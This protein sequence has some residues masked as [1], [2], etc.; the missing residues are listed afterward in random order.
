MKQILVGIQDLL[1]QPNAADPAQTEGYHLFIQVR[2][3]PLLCDLVLDFMNFTLLAWIISF[4][5]VARIYQ[6]YDFVVYVVVSICNIIHLFTGPKQH[7]IGLAR[8][9]CNVKLLCACRTDIDFC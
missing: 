3:Q 5:V 6:V 4:V 1:D 7:Q 9:D 2:L 8:I